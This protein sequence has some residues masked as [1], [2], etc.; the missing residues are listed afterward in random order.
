MLRASVWATLAVVLLLTQSVVGAENRD[1]VF[2]LQAASLF[3]EIQSDNNIELFPPLQ[4]SEVISQD[5]MLEDGM[6]A[7]MHNS[8]S[9]RWRDGGISPVASVLVS[10]SNYMPPDTFVL[11][12]LNIGPFR[13]ELS[14]RQQS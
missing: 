1:V 7:I 11:G 2:N 14:G 12:R 13:G 10:L 6:P 5:C 4:N 8:S 3:Q 9:S